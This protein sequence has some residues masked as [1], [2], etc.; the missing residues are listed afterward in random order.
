MHEV[1]TDCPVKI[2][3][4]ALSEFKRLL[5]DKQLDTS[6]G[7]RLGVKGGGCAGFSYVLG[8]DTPKPEDETFEMDGLKIY[9]NKA[10]GLYL[11]GMEVDY[12]NGLNAR[13]FVFNNPNADKTCG[14]GSSFSA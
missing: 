1:K 14:C 9:M 8:L 7:L 5:A 4:T 12:Q 3:D 13:G 11:A 6:N 10:H 2:T